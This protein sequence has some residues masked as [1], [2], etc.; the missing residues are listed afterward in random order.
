M[1]EPIQ[2]REFIVTLEPCFSGGFVN[3]IVNMNST[4][5]RVVS[6]AAN[7]MEYSWAMPP[8]YVYDT[9]VFHWTAAIEWMDAYGNPV[10]ADTNN[11]GEITMDEAYQYALAMDQDD[12]NPQY[13]EWPAGYGA[14]LTMTGSGPTSD[15]TVKLKRGSL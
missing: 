5:P 1:L 8:D 13:G 6:T 3:D 12:E 7:D 9:Y 2:C 14:T 15:G 10:D 4:V 11:D